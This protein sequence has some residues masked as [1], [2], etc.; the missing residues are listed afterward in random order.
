MT[1]ILALSGAWPA[2][3]QK[4]YAPPRDVYGHPVLEGVWAARWLTNL[5]RPAGTPLRLDAVAGAARARELLTG[6]GGADNLDPEISDPDA[7]TLAIVGGEHRASLI[8]DPPD[9]RLPLTDAGRAYLRALP[10]PGFDGPEARLTNERCVAGVSNAGMLIAPAGMLKQVVQTR[11]HVVIH[12]EAFSELRVFAPGAGRQYVGLATW[13]GEA[14][15]RW[16]GDVLVVE[17]SGFRPDDKVRAAPFS[18]FPI[19]PQTRITERFS[20]SGPRELLYQFEVEDPELYTRPWRAEYAMVLTNERIFEFA[21]HEGNYGLANI[22]S[23]AREEEKR[24]A[25]GR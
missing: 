10:A 11:D 18:R 7:N 19:R 6:R 15:A 14:S 4:P 1:A 25:A 23:G 21:C 2:M 9:G 12:S 22:L 24:A 17:T 16:D 8:V 13:G 5:E 20:R 3:A